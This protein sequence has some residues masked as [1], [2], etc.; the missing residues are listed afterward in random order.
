MVPR[1]VRA[2][3]LPVGV[4]SDRTFVA[5]AL[6]GALFYF[7]FYGL[8]FAMSLMLQQGRSLS[9][10]VSG[11]L[12]LP[13]T[14]LISV[15]TLRTARL[16]QRFGRPRI[17]GISQ[18]VLAATLLAVAWAASASSLWPLMVALVPV[19][20]FSG[21]LVPAMTSQA[22]AAVE[23]ALHGAASAA[24]NTSRQIGGAIGIATFGP[25]LGTTHNLK[26]G[27]ITCVLV[28]AAAT[29]V[30]LLLTLTVHVLDQ[31][32]RHCSSAT[33]QDH[34]NAGLPPCPARPACGH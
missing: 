8:L 3:L 27:F 26:A 34:R 7:T 1:S 18:A 17:I 32:S 30:T 25:L 6:Q 29:A 15:G 10:L 22:I 21:L 20:F 5:T 16:T 9:A 2:P 33:D 13:L 14:G 12:F 11:L 28:T 24:F 31:H 23:P 4:Y 19:G